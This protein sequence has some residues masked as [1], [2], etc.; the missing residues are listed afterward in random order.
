[1]IYEMVNYHIFCTLE[2]TEDVQ[3]TFQS[4]TSQ[5]LFNVLLV[6]FLS[7]PRKWP[8]G[9]PMP[10]HNTPRSESNLLFHLKRICAAPQLN[11]AGGSALQLPLDA[12]TQWLEAECCVEKMWLASIG[13]ETNIKVPRIVFIKICGNIAKHNFARL[14]KNVEDICK[15]LKTNGTVIDL[16]QA[17]FVIPEFY[18]WFHTG[19]F[20]YHG[21]AIAEFLNNIRWSIYEYLRPEFTRSFTKE[22]PKSLAYRFNY[23]PDCNK[24]VIQAMYW[25]LMNEVR[26]KPFMPKFEVTRYLKMLY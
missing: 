17:Y 8:F 22:K 21:S 24:S 2:R 20:N 1:M 15:I 13:V 3:L 4:R 25:D 23:P 6:D 5:R 12:F 14:S 19:V 7:Q 10:P 9:L 11:P 16:E 18:E 26:V